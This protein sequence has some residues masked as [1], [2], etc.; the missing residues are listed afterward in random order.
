MSVRCRSLEASPK[1]PQGLSSQD[2]GVWI[3]YG[4]RSKSPS[5]PP[6]K[7]VQCCL[8]GAQESNCEFLEENARVAPVFGWSG[9]RDAMILPQLCGSAPAGR[10]RRGTPRPGRAA[11]CPV[12]N[13]RQPS[14]QSPIVAESRLNYAVRCTSPRK[15]NTPTVATPSNARADGSGIAKGKDRSRNLRLSQM[16][17]SRLNR[18]RTRPKKRRRHYD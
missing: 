13:P 5:V 1:A 6:L 17:S 2:F 16:A 3:V 18:R 8:R 12:C 9:G 14:C 7:G 11:C 15:V 4:P 10:R